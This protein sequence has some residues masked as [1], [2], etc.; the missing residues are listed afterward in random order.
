MK[1]NV[2]WCSICLVV[3]AER[4]IYPSFGGVAGNVFCTAQ[5]NVFWHDHGLFLTLCNSPLQLLNFSCTL[6]IYWTILN[7]SVARTVFPRLHRNCHTALW[8]CRYHQLLDTGDGPF[9]ADKQF[10]GL[11]CEQ[12]LYFSAGPTNH[13]GSN[14][15]WAR[16]LCKCVPHLLRMLLT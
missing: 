1:V 5:Y 2:F 16:Q 10:E 7:L 8:I 9:S 13:I 6:I 3:V 4:L 11:V 14:V 15:I 12:R